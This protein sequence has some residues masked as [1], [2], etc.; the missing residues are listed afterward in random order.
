MGRPGCSIC[1]QQHGTLLGLK[2]PLE[3]DLRQTHDV[4][5]GTGV[6]LAPLPT[7]A[8][9]P[10]TADW[11]SISSVRLHGTFRTD[12]GF[13]AELTE[14]A[15]DV[16]SAANNMSGRFTMTARFTNFWGPQVI[17]KQCEIVTLARVI[18]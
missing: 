2:A 5:T 4:V 10:V 3:F 12:E 15:S 8:V 17:V 16:D 1:Q 13:E 7:G 18:R 14:W 11:T 9:G 6:V